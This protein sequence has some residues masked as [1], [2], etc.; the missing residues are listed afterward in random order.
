MGQNF[1]KIFLK[2]SIDFPVPNFHY[3]LKCFCT[4]Y[5]LFK[6]LLLVYTIHKLSYSSLFM[7]IVNF[8][9]KH[10]FEFWNYIIIQLSTQNTTI[11]IK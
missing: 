10:G 1:N 9:T 4:D 5:L 3:Y 11:Q 8:T 2:K 7:N 6:P